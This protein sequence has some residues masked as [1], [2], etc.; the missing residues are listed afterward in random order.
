MLEE[1]EYNLLSKRQ[2]LV[3]RYFVEVLCRV[4]ETESDFEMEDRLKAKVLS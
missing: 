3:I 4:L 2:N 1:S